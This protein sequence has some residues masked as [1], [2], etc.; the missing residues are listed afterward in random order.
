MI[1][2]NIKQLFN[3]LNSYCITQ[4]ESA[5]GLATTR[6]HHDIVWEHLFVKLID[7]D[8]GD[9]PAIIDVYKLSIVDIKKSLLGF[10]DEYKAGNTGRPAFSSNFLELIEQAWVLA[11]V[12][13]NADKIRSGFLLLALLTPS[14]RRMFPWLED[15]WPTLTK[16]KVA[17]AIHAGFEDSVEEPVQVTEDGVQKISDRQTAEGMEALDKYTENLTIKAKDGK[18]DPVFARENEIRQMIDILTR[19]RKNNPILVGEPGTGKT[20]IVEG[21]ALKIVEGDVPPAFKD[22][23]LLTLDMGLLQAGASVKGEFENR[24]KTVIQAIKDYPKPVITFIDEAHTI[25]G[26]G[27]SAGQ[28]DAANLLKPALARGELRTVA[29]TTWSEYKKYFEKDPALARRFQLVKVA[30]PDDVGAF[31][32]LRG[33]KSRYEEHHGVRMTDEGV[34]AAVTLSRRYITG[35][36]LPDKAIDLLD[37]AAARV[38]LSQHATPSAI[39]HINQLMATL[40]REKNAL[41]KDRPTSKDQE[42]IDEQLKKINEEI[43]KLSVKHSELIENWEKEKG[44]VDDYMTA[45]KEMDDSENEDKQDLEANAKQKAD[46]LREF[47]KDRPLIFPELD[48]EVVASVIADWTGIPVGNMLGDEADKLLN[49]QGELSQRIIG[50]NQALAT[51]TNSLRV[52]KSG[53]SDPAK[54]MGVFMLVGPSGVGK[55]ETALAIADLLFGG[56]KYVTTINMSEYQEKHNVSRLIGSPPG[57]VGYGEGGVLTEAVRQKPYTVVLLDEVEKAHP[58]VMELFYQVFDKGVLSDGEG[59]VINFSNTVIM[60][61]T[62]LASEAIMQIMEA[63][64]EGAVPMAEDVN[65]AIRPMLNQHFRP[66]FLAR[67]MLIPY[68]PLSQET[69]S[70]IVKLKLNTVENRLQDQGASMKYDQDLIDWISARCQVSENGARNVEHVINCDLLPRIS[71]ELLSSLG[72]KDDLKG[73]VLRLQVEE[74]QIIFDF[75]NLNETSE[76]NEPPETTENMESEEDGKLDES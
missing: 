60:L 71:V 22:A 75:S 49:M 37:T 6:G 63:A 25:I 27:G 51:I 54:P 69:I 1:T 41:E 62:N 53:L 16:E 15:I 4:L 65:N 7:D 43:E 2:E 34:T 38:A 67:L 13:F 32:I 11:S 73:K 5:V 47:Q 55:T 50:Q 33:L 74:D 35:R 30:E 23:D 66:A 10:L 24:L 44:F 58:D 76:M 68:Y 29:A 3:K 70:K 21:L 18:I 45:V 8:K 19:R 72:N 28:S 17:N 42:S 48:D 39:E 14:G 46:D 26:A 40:E 31:A 12:E 36:Q 59:R 61:T 57:Y 9:I 52:A 56:E 20:A 64:P